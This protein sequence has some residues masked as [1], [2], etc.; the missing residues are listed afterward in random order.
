MRAWPRLVY[1]ALFIGAAAVAALALDAALRPSA[2]ADLLRAVLVASLC[3]APGLVHRKAWPAAFVL[4][5]LGAL[6]VART[7]LLLPPDVEGFGAQLAYYWEQVGQGAILYTQKVFPMTLGDAPALRLFWALVVYGLTG[8]AALLGLGLRRPL[9]GLTPLLVLLCFG[10]TVD[11][12]PR[13]LW[14]PVLFLVLAASALGLSRSLKRPGWRV[15]DAVPSLAVGAVGAALALLILGAAPSVAARPWQDWRT[16]DPFRSG[17]SVYS[18]NWLQNYPQLLDPANDQLVMKVRSPVPAYWRANALDTFTGY[19]WVSTQSFLDSIPRAPSDD[20]RTYTYA[21]PDYSPTPPGE[22]VEQSFQLRSVYTNYFFT[23]GDPLSLTLAQQLDIRLNDARALRVVTALGPALDYSLTALAPTLR[24][25]DLVG[26]GADYPEEVEPYLSLPFPRATQMTGPDPDATWRATISETMVDADQWADLY[27]LN[28]E[29][30]ADATDPYEITLRLERYLRRYYHY[31]LSPPPS[32]YSSPFAAFLFDTRRGYCQH[33]AGT[34]ALLLRFNGIPSRV[35]VGFTAGQ[36]DPAGVFT[37]TTNNAHA[38]VE[39]FFPTVGWVSFDP[40]PGRNL[41]TPGPSSTTPGFVDP[42]AGSPTGGGGAVPTLPPHQTS[43]G[44]TLPGGEPDGAGGSWIARWP[45][46]PWSLAIVVL[47]A[48]WPAVRTWWRR[49]D[50][51][52]GPPVRRLEASLRL[53]RSTLAD[54]GVFVGPASTL[55]ELFEVVRA[56]VGLLPEP[57]L[58]PRL[59]AVLFG[60]RAARPVDVERTELFRRRVARV[61]RHRSGTLRALLA[62]YRRPAASAKTAARHTIADL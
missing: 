24:P 59:Q 29:A 6:L 8:L 61:L 62:L 49:W 18:F 22:R 30:I 58:L 14:A 50:L 56:K 4:L 38:W 31:D 33:F 54:Y 35:A 25:V 12:A 2:S 17:G 55:E 21:V 47:A 53:L 11:E 23:G 43:P 52:H 5:P 60:G 3:A 34:L 1:L 15:R 41:P 45:W 7:S 48:G 20:G 10:L 27:S 40:T 28:R 42:F 13:A 36:E 26:L 44:E 39:V 46:L 19:A 16:W 57:D 51:H 32:D 37:V 9:A